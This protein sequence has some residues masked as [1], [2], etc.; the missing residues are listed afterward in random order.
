M[1]HELKGI[2][3][4]KADLS[5]L[6]RT[7]GFHFNMS[8]VSPG[9]KCWFG[10]DSKTF[11][12]SVKEVKGKV[13]GRICERGPNFSSWVRFSGKGLALLVEGAETCSALKVGE[14]FRNVWV[15]GEIQCLL[16]LHSNRA[17]RFLL[18]SAWDVEG[19]EFSV[20]FP[21][22]SDQRREK[23]KASS[24]QGLVLRGD[25]EGKKGSFSNSFDS[26]NA[27]N[28]RKKTYKD[29]TWYTGV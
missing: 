4:N 12:I 26:H 9:G 7:K 25:D 24:V 20:V 19:K 18:C 17:G 23:S 28:E 3:N 11:E 21:V 29:H 1:V 16:D 6:Y 8:V 15:E 14:C 5:F 10:L 13:T 2:Q 27:V 22:C